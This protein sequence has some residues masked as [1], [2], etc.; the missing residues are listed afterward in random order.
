MK[1]NN[2][3]SDLDMVIAAIPE[4]FDETEYGRTFLLLL[5]GLLALLAASAVGR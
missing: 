4:S 5:C 3:Q 2:A 1:S